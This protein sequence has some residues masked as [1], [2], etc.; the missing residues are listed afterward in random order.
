MLIYFV[1]LY[2]HYELIK[3]SNSRSKIAIV[4]DE[5][6]LAQLFTEALRSHGFEVQSFTNPLFALDTITLTHSNYSLVLTDIRMPG[7]T[8][9]EL[10]ENLFRIDNDIKILLMT[11]IDCV[12]TGNFN[13]IQKPIPISRLLEIVQRTLDEKVHKIMIS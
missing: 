3:A 10:A 1:I 2:G 13:C 9:I 11:A 4:D 12:D 8:G 6:D 5:E 7:L